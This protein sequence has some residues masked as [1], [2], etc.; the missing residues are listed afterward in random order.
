[1]FNTLVIKQV[2]RCLD[3]LSHFSNKGAIWYIAG[4]SYM[5]YDTKFW[6]QILEKIIINLVQLIVWHE[7]EP[8]FKD[9]INKVLIKYFM[10]LIWSKKCTIVYKKCTI[11]SF[12]GNTRSNF[13]ILD[14]S[15]LNLEI[16]TFMVKKKQQS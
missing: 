12:V 14:E 15:S 6:G 3:P 10:Y 2:Y 5:A 9:W 1:M 13:T 7:K 4:R 11:F 16:P 8:K